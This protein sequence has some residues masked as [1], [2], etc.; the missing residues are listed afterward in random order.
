MHTLNIPKS[1]WEGVSLDDNDSKRFLRSWFNGM[2]DNLGEPI[3]ANILTR[4]SDDRT[5]K[6][7]ALFQAP[8]GKQKEVIRTCG[9]PNFTITI[10]DPSKMRWE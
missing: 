2:A 4:T 7:R 1:V 10:R 5:L 6:I 9:R 3:K 8:D